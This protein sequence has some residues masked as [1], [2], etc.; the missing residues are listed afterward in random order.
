MLASSQAHL[1]R[2][3]KEEF[4]R[5]YVFRCPGNNVYEGQYLLGTSIARPL[6]AKRQIE[7]AARSAPTRSVT[8][9]PAGNDQV[10][11]RARLYALEPRHQGDR[12]RGGM[13]FRQPRAIARLRRE[14][15]DP[16]P[17]TKE[18][19]RLPATRTCSIPPRK[20]KCSRTPRAEAPN[21]SPADHLARRS[22]RQGDDDRDR[23]RARRP[24]GDR[25][26]GAAPRGAW[27]AQPVGHDN[28]L[29]RLDWARTASSA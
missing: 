12:A 15:P 24:G 11:V 29:G 7:I 2:G 6:I 10:T 25:R 28:G 9:P 5:E 14:A 13:G 17:R 16:S 1:H 4:V 21:M 22:A 20:A 3:S 18:A 23:V 8:A 27:R 19:T 26:R